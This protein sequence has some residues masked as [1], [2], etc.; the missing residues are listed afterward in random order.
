[1]Q[2]LHFIDVAGHEFDLGILEVRSAII[3]H[4]NPADNIHEIAFF[5]RDEIVAGLPRKPL[6]DIGDLR[7]DLGGGGG[8]YLPSEGWL[9]DVFFSQRRENRLTRQGELEFAVDFHDGLNG[10]TPWHIATA[11]DFSRNSLV[12]LVRLPPNEIEGLPFKEG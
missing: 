1:M 9:E 2:G 11:D 5:R 4:G 6:G 3:L 10:S 12:R 7:V 8:V